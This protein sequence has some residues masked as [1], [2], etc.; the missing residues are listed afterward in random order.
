MLFLVIFDVI[1]GWD[2]ETPT[3]LQQNPNKITLLYG[4]GFG[5]KIEVGIGRTPTP[6][7]LG[8]NPKFFQKTDLKASLIMAWAH[9]QQM[10][11]KWAHRQQ[12]GI[13]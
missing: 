11:N 6:P 10:C 13:Y 4:C 9:G 1:F 7:Q 12:M 2:C 8:K 3:I 5:L